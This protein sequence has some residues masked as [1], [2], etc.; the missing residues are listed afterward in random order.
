MLTTEAWRLKKW[1]RGESACQW[2]EI[3]ITFMRSRIRIR[4]RI[5]VKDRIG[6]PIEGKPVTTERKFLIYLEKSCTH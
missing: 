1:S 2:S 4:V 3:G 6:I 5:K